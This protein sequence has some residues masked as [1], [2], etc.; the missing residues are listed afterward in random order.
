MR[1]ARNGFV[2]LVG[3]SLAASMTVVAVPVQAQSESRLASQSI[4][5]ESHTHFRY[6]HYSW[7]PAGGNTIEFTLQ[8]AFRRSFTPFTAYPCLDPATLTNVPCS[9]SDGLP[10]VGDIFQ[11]SIGGT[12]FFPGDGSAIGSPL[13][14]LLY[15]VTSTDPANESLFALALDPASLPAIDTT[16]SHTYAAPADYIAFTD[17]CCRISAATGVNAHINNPDGGYRVETIVNVGAGN[18]SPVSA[19]FPIVL[20]P[21]DTVCSFPVP[22][23]DPDGDALNFR[24][25]APAEASSSGGFTQPGPPSAP[26]LA[27]ISP[28]GLYTWDTT[29][30]AVGP[31]GSRTL[32][33]TQVTIEDLDGTGGVKSKVAIDFFI[34]LIQC[35]PEG[36]DPPVFPPP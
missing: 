10:G 11:E 5:D 20:C 30:A 22:G 24:L 3:L 34:Q 23:A 26:N 33:S 2:T 18:N 27:T 12:Q 25:S 32:Y 28:A 29:G 13:G 35:P 14:P 9:A 16:I 4:D 36:C 21:I 1:R 31:A 19:V 7:K 15:L 8:N 6:G 17:S